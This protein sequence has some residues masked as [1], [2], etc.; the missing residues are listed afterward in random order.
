[1]SAELRIIRRS[2]GGKRERGP[3]RDQ[4]ATVHP[5]PHLLLG[6]L[7]HAL[8]EEV[9]A[10]MEKEDRSR[11]WRDHTDILAQAFA[12]RGLSEEVITAI[13]ADHLLRVREI[14]TA[15][16]K[17]SKAR[18]K[19]YI[20]FSR[21]PELGT[22]IMVGRRRAVLVGVEPI[23]R[24]SD[25]DASWL[26]TWDI[27]GRRATSGLRSKSVQWERPNGKG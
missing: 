4:P 7:D 1:M 16:D 12:D 25:G 9:M 20:D 13:L 14:H 22:E 17:A 5:M 26:L 6:P 27:G 19:Y 18:K 23:T 3:T 11:F 2:K 10:A 8:I 15:R 21:P 24:R